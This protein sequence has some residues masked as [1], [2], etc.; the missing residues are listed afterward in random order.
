MRSL[1]DRKI[2]QVKPLLGQNVRGFT[3]IKLAKACQLMKDNDI[4]V[5]CYSETWRVTPNGFATEVT[6]DGCL[7][8]FH[9]EKVGTGRGGRNR[10]GVAIILRTDARDAYE[11]GG[12]KHS[13]GEDGRTLFV[14]IPLEGGGVW[15]VGSTYAPTSGE[16]STVRQAFY[17]DVSTCIGA[18]SQD[19]RLSVY[20]DAN[21][22]P[23]RGVRARDR[24]AGAPRS[25]GPYGC[26]DV[27]AAG[28]EFREFLQLHKLASAATFFASGKHPFGRTAQAT[29]WHPATGWGYQIDHIIVRR[30][31]LGRVH[32]CRARPSLAVNSDHVPVLLQ[33]QLGRMQRKQQQPGRQTANTDALRAP[34]VKRAY[35]ELVGEKLSAWRVANLNASLEA[36]A[37]ALRNISA[38]VAQEVCGKR[39]RRQQG[40]FA[41]NFV[42]VVVLV[43]KR[44][45][46]TSFFA[47][48]RRRS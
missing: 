39:E 25:L 38:E 35:G 19:I 29:W 20:M 33:V 12:S 34:D 1:F 17:D 5:S 37:E 42:A 21:A 4:Q 36:R 15:R 2:G 28:Q 48:P 24:P 47:L 18:E 40:W 10:R 27:N 44:N 9:G 16:S 46:A 30:N 13:H 7:V 11:S 23:G 6:D 22:S 3:E 26:S 8:L 31:Q 32:N 45:R 41:N 43:D 14:D